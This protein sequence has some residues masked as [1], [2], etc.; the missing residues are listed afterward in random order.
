MHAAALS[1]RCGFTNVRPRMHNTVGGL[2]LAASKSGTKTAAKKS[3]GAAKKSSGGAAKKS[4]AKKTGG[5]AK[6][7]G[8]AA[9]KS[10]AKSASKR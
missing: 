8:G 1:G 5:A 10:S 9:K 2:V 4:A 6:K 7:S 3:S